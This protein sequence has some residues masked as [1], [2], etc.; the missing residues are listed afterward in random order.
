MILLSPTLIIPLRKVLHLNKLYS[1]ICT[2]SSPTHTLTQTAQGKPLQQRPGEQQKETVAQDSQSSS[3]RW[4]Q[5]VSFNR[6]TSWKLLPPC[7]L[8][9]STNYEKQQQTHSFSDHPPPLKTH[10]TL[11]QLLYSWDSAQCLGFGRC[12]PPG[13]CRTR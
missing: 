11:I 4:P 3:M 10:S 5:T 13:Q 7:C 2:L 1:F 8:Q 6:Q 12:Q 9:Q